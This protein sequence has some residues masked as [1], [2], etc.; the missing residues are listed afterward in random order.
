MSVLPVTTYEQAL[1]ALRSQLLT[2]TD[3]P[4][5]MIING[6]S[7]YGPD[8]WRELSDT[9]GVA[10]DIDT[11]FIVFE[12]KE[13]QN[14]IFVITTDTDGMF[15]VTPY[16]FFIKIYGNKCHE[17]AYKVSSIFKFPPVVESLQNAG[18]KIVSTSQVS[19]L[20]EFINNVRWPRC[21]VEID[22]A[23]NFEVP[24]SDPND[25]G[26]AE[27]IAQPIKVIDI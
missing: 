1:I 12:F 2:Y 16:G 7:L 22:V 21:D 14:E 10:P 24:I 27:S 18:I 15:A 20:N 26:Y 4:G 17:V 3:I 19:S 11:P 25:P 8:V 9:I 23:C 13:I 5:R 6:D